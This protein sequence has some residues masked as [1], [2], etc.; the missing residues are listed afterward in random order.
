MKLIFR[1]CIL[2]NLFLSFNPLPAKNDYW[3]QFVHYQMDVT[4]LPI[5]H[6]VVGEST[7]EYH[8]NSPDT[9]RNVFMHLY[10]NAFKDTR[11]LYMQEA[12]RFNGRVLKSPKDG[13]RIDIESFSITYSTTSGETL[14]SREYKVN[15]TILEAPLIQ[16]L[17]PGQK[18]T[19]SLSFKN[20]VRKH[21]GRAGYHGFQ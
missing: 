12:Q 14:I 13:G 1:I 10:P 3:Q 5:E 16:P 9:L 11:T 15:N 2:S 21:L 4:L 18:V 17:A 20:V 19:I 6:S 7:I 8:N